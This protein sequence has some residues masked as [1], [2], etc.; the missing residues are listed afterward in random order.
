LGALSVDPH[1]RDIPGVIQKKPIPAID[2][3]RNIK[4]QA[5]LSGRCGQRPPAKIR[6]KF[7][8]NPTSKIENNV[9]VILNNLSSPQPR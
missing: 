2:L 4:M 1:G 8:G 6:P 7:M 5:A 3:P 9:S